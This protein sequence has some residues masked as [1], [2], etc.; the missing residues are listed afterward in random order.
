MQP[1]KHFNINNMS[2]VCLDEYEE[3]YKDS[4][5]VKKYLELYN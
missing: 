4:K 2:K 5:N 1:I 3:F